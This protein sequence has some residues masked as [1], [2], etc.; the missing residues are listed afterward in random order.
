MHR[1]ATAAFGPPLAAWALATG[2]IL[3]AC[4]WAGASP[5]DAKPWTHGDSGL[6]LDIARHGY[7]LYRC[8]A[9]WC[10]NAGWFPALPWLTA[11]LHSVTGLSYVAAAV[12]VAWAFH[13]G[14]L[15]LLWTTFLDRRLTPGAASALL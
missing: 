8:G 2:A 7:T 1:S 14:T 10:G 9:D 15:V 5:W 4:V 3:A 12:G 13:A 6:Y 11:G